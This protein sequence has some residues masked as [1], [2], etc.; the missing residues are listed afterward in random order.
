MNVLYLLGSVP[1]HK[2]TFI[3]REIQELKN[4]GINVIILVIN[5]FYETGIE[6]KFKYLFK[7]SYN[8]FALVLNPFI[9]LFYHKK[10]I[11]F[12]NKGAAWKTGFENS[13]IS[14]FRLVLAGIFLESGFARLL[15]SKIEINHIHSHHLFSASL[16]T[17]G[18][19]HFLNTKYSL[20][21]H[22]L[23][24]YFNSD[25]LTKTVQQA[26]FLRTV[27][28]E[29]YSYFKSNFSNPN[30]NY[31]ANGVDVLAFE[32]SEVIKPNTL[33][34]LAV[35]YF[36][37]KKGFDILIKSCRLIKDQGVKFSCTIIGEGPEKKLFTKLILDHQL[38]NEISILP[39]LDFEKLI[40]YFKRSHVLA[41]PSRDPKR[42]TRDGLPTVILEAL[43][44]KLPVVASDFAGISDAI[45]HE[46]TG[47]LI[48]SDSE[49][50]L[51]QSIL[52]I[53]N[54]HHLV[55]NLTENGLDLVE[56]NFSLSKNIAK[57]ASLFKT[58][59]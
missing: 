16:F 4:S 37:D 59:S 26:S 43:A 55:N 3:N 49:T 53:Y 46:K 48:E 28:S 10:S 44:L 40:P 56:R 34:I 23:S 25:F 58:A 54:D 29:T 17:P 42:S 57:L 5:P 39:F 33:T 32:T 9:N 14:F 35:G 30:I 31:I 19:A 15:K 52:R 45:I 24:K 20:T 1:N 47:L 2:H 7:A 41:V 38:E 11:L 50:E 18:I 21:I 36:L 13:K 8:P 51:A 6:A 22:T 27:T 12:S